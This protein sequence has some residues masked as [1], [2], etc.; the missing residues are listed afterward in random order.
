LVTNGCASVE[1]LKEVLPFIDAMNIDLKGFSEEYF[2][3]VGGDF[4]MTKAFIALAQK[5]CTSN[6]R[7]RCS[8][9]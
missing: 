2:R 9:A 5:N 4:E 1:A 7:P 6:S 8:A 3:Y